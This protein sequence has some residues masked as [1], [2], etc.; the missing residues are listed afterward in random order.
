M[1]K[2]ITITINVDDLARLENDRAKA[3]RK[4]QRLQ[5]K[6]ERVVDKLSAA[7]VPIYDILHTNTVKLDK[8]WGENVRQ[9]RDEMRRERRRA[10]GA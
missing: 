5:R 3:I 9:A 4:A 10:R 2:P 7:G 1:R 8:E 6:Y